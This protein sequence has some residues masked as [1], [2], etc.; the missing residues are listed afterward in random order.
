MRRAAFVSIA[1]ASLALSGCAG[2]GGQQVL[3]NLQGCHRHYEG[4]VSAGLG[5]GFSGTVTID[6]PP[7]K[8]TAEAAP[9]VRPEA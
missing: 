2:L 6:C 9:V 7:T 4:V 5:A 3:Q 1:A 8:A